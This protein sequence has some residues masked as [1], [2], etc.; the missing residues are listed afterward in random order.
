MYVICSDYQ[1]K[2]VAS[3]AGCKESNE[4]VI[5]EA[6]RKVNTKLVFKKCDTFDPRAVGVAIG[7]VL[8]NIEKD[9][10]VIVNYTGGTAVVRLILGA[11]GVALTMFMKTKIIYSID[12]PG[13]IK[14]AADHT[15][16]LKDIFRELRSLH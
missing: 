7:E 10:Q 11:V 1:L 15:E 4:S 8:K 9:D 6:A 14:V 16:A 13:G 3:T 2:I 12:Y 5:K